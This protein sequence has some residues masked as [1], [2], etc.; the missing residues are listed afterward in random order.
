MY[1]WR[2]GVIGIGRTLPEAALEI[3]RGGKVSLYAFRDRLMIWDGKR[4]AYRIPGLTETMDQQKAL[5]VLRERISEFSAYSVGIRLNQP[6]D[7]SFV[8]RD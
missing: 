4:E 1:C 3:A 5:D 2:D 6:L 8:G 7:I